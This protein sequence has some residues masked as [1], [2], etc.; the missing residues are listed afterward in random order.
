[1]AVYATL[2]WYELTGKYFELLKVWTLKDNVLL[3]LQEIQE[4]TKAVTN[5]TISEPGDRLYSGSLDRTAKV[6]FSAA[7][8]SMSDSLLT[9][10]L[11]RWITDLVYWKGSN[12]L[13][14]GAWYEGPDS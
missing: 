3:L 7:L 5:L 4:H 12:T 10:I 8:V 9:K 2:P 11:F 6:K 1:L 14:A 13:W